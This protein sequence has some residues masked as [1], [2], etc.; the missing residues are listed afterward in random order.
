MS[1]VNVSIG[2]D[3]IEPIIK[4]KV[5]ASIVKAVSGEQD[6]VT[7]FIAQALEIKVDEDGKVQSNDYRNKFT[8]LEYM[9]IETLRDCA[10]DAIKSWIEDNKGEV[11]KALIAQLKTTKSTSA[12][13][14]SIINGLTN[15]VDSD[16]RM[17][18]EVKLNSLKDD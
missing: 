1:E 3:L 4:A 16:W 8:L 13:A 2:K 6:M 11:R 9:C 10:R 7:R 15:C 17:K 12:L 5:Q 18:V 14:K